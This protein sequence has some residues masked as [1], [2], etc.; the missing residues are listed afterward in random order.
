MNSATI[1]QFLDILGTKQLID[2]LKIIIRL[3]DNENNPKWQPEQKRDESRYFVGYWNPI[4]SLN[5][6]Q[7]FLCAVSELSFLL[8][9]QSL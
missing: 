3:I 8:K 2:N 5:D 4:P 1:T 7:S 9:K 6:H